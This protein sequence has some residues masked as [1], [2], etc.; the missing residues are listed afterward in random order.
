MVQPEEGSLL[1]AGGAGW[2]R[3]DRCDGAVTEVLGW[4]K[5]SFQPSTWRGGREHV[6]VCFAVYLGGAFT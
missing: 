4:P 6:Q 2:E 5:S 1:L 3:G